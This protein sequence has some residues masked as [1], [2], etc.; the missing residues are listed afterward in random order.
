MR[1]DWT[2]VRSK[3]LYFVCVKVSFLFHADLLC[4]G[5]A[6]GSLSTC[7]STCVMRTQLQVLT[8]KVSSI[9]YVCMAHWR[10]RAC[11]SVFVC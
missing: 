10:V 7:T 9:N 6:C 3:G 5:A 4:N 1:L 11:V 8:C 2:G